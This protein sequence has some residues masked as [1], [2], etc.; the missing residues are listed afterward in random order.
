MNVQYLET[1]STERVLHR[2]SVGRHDAA[3]RAASSLH[4]QRAVFSAGLH[5]SSRAARNHR[6][7]PVRRHEPQRRR[8][9]ARAAA[10]A[11]GCG[12]RACCGQ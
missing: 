12:H 10:S 1:A 2:V 7:T 9:T 3:A 6:L 5:G 11:P 8:G 4:Q